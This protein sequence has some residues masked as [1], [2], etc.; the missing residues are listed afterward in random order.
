MP[1]SRKTFRWM[2]A[3][4]LSHTPVSQ[5][6]QAGSTSDRTTQASYGRGLYG[7]KLSPDGLST[8]SAGSQL[9]PV[10]TLLR[11]QAPLQYLVI[12]QARGWALTWHA[13]WCRRCDCV[14]AG[15]RFA[16]ERGYLAGLGFELSGPGH[17]DDAGPS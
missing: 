13:P 1:R 17:Q 9:G 8:G 12:W 3:P 7:R 14:G 5:A 16:R 6:A 11:W 10:R 2:A 4:V 15:W